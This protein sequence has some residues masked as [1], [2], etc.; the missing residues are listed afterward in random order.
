MKPA[1]VYTEQANVRI[2]RETKAEIDFLR[3]QGVDTAKLQRD[4]VKEVV[5]K[6]V[7]QFRKSAS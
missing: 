2:D 6:A 1:S 3:S 4:A 5:A 7:Q